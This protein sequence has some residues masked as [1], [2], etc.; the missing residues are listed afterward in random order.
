ME[1]KPSPTRDNLFVTLSH[2]KDYRRKQGLR[3]TLPSLLLITILAIMQGA[4]SERAI[5][6][7]AQNNKK[8]LI[9]ELKIARKEVPTR[10]VFMG[11]VQRVDFATLEHLF[12]TWTLKTV[13]IKKGEWLSVD[14][15]AI[16]GTFKNSH[17]PLQDFVSLVTIFQ[18]KKK[19]VLSVGRIN[20]KKENEIP[21]VRDLIE[22]LDLQG[23]I[24]TLDA[25]HCQSKTMKSI[26]ESKNDYVVGVKDN[27]KRMLA[28]LKKTA[29]RVRM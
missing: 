12:H 8:E 20:T 23:V 6:R 21:T 13:T 14:G 1:T 11:L 15:K 26:V 27:Q 3:H 24:F 10:R 19:Q 18:S 16:R 28:T 5:A 22:T 9:H 2:L 29:T 7:F 25:L 17:D 4:R